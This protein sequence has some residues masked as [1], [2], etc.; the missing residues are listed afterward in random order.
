MTA[1]DPSNAHLGVDSLALPSQAVADRHGRRDPSTLANSGPVEPG[2]AT[3]LPA[4]SQRPGH[5]QLGQGSAVNWDKE[6]LSTFD[7][8]AHYASFS[9]PSSP[10]ATSSSSRAVACE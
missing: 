7:N 10:S 5:V 4:R 9:S 1:A 2:S 6:V 3:R 8:A